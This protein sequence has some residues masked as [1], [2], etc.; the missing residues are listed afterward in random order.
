[1]GTLISFPI[2]RFNLYSD[3]RFREGALSIDQRF[4]FFTS[5][6]AG[7]APRNF[8]RGLGATQ[9]NF[10]LRRTFALDRRVNLLFRAEAS[11]SSTTPSLVL[12]IPPS[13]MRRFGQATQTLDESLATMSPLPRRAGLRSCSSHSKST[14]TSSGESCELPRKLYWRLAARWMPWESRKTRRPYRSIRLCHGAAFLAT[15]FVPPRDQ[16][17]GERE[18]L[19]WCNRRTCTPTKTIRGWEV[20]SGDPSWRNAA[21]AR[22]KRPAAPEMARMTITSR[23]SRIR[24]G[25]SQVLLVEVSTGRV[26]PY[27]AAAQNIS[28]YSI[29]AHGDTV[30]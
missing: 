14:S 17:L 16:S 15:T 7:N 19:I 27:F 29:S 1:M 9:V 3:Q 24:E 4:S 8:V 10:A 13:R 20:G 6:E 30:V 5:G 12:W 11:T 21:P 22:G 2:S 26:S 23:C 18:S 28:E 25:R